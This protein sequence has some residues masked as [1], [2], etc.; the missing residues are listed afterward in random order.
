MASRARAVINTAPREQ[1]EGRVHK[2]ER[3]WVVHKKGTQK[4]EVQLELLR[5]I[6]TGGWPVGPAEGEGIET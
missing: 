5:W 6:Q 3:R 1:I 4:Q 2:W